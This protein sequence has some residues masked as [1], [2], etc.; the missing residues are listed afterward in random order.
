M[1]IRLVGSDQTCSKEQT[2]EFTVLVMAV[3]WTTLIAV[4]LTGVLRAG[5]HAPEIGIRAWSDSVLPMLGT[6]G[7]IAAAGQTDV[8]VALLSRLSESTGTDAVPSIGML[9]ST[10][11]TLWARAALGIMRTSSPALRERHELRVSGPYAVTRHPIHTGLLGMLLSSALITGMAAA[12]AVFVLAAVG[13]SAKS[14]AEERLLP[15]RV[16]RPWR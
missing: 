15:S 1:E 16:R 12:W 7:A 11:L 13:L 9:A 14:R 8:A 5:W 6:A 2:M 10:T 4:W 3:C